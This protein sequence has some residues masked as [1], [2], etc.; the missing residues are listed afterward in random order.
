MIPHTRPR[1]SRLRLK[2][3]TLVELMVAMTIG[4]IVLGAIVYLFIGIR[5]TFR[6][7]DSQSRMQ[8]NARYALEMVARD[9]RMAGFIGCG[10]LEFIPVNVMASPAPANGISFA[11]AV[12]GADSATGSIGGIALAGADTITITGALDGVV[13]IA[14]EATDPLNANLKVYGNP[15]GYVQND[16]L[17]VTD[18]RTM[19]VFRVTNSPSVELD[20]AV[21]I[22]LTHSNGSNTGNRIGRYGLDAFIMRVGTYTYFIGL[23][24]ATNRPA[25]YRANLSRGLEGAVQTRELVDNVQDMQIEYG[26]HEAG[27]TAPESYLS[28]GA[29]ADWTRVSSV[30]INLLM[31]SADD[32]IVSEPQTYIFNGASVTADD[33]RLYQTY[34]ATIA[35]RNRVP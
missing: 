6:T 24:P 8:E 30:R 17:S 10:N 15:Y 25:L 23:N 18:C 35:V 27:E 19:D 4:L 2:G 11:T 29:I 14:E 22:T 28:A 32:A 33:R 26:V 31:V 9:V 20:T 16:V 21:Q 13:S 34:T 5:Q 12:T 7:T 3:F 1:R